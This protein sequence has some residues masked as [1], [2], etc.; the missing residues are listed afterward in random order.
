MRA[1]GFARDRWSLA[2]QRRRIGVGG[3]SVRQHRGGL[4]GRVTFSGGQEEIMFDAMLLGGQLVVAAAELVKRLMVAVLDDSSFLDHQDLVCPANGGEPMG[5]DKRGAPLHQIGEPFLNQGFRLGVETRGGLVE[6][7]NAGVGQDGARDR[8]SL[9][10]PARQLH[11]AFADD[12]VVLQLIFLG[13]LIHAGNGASP[14]DLLFRRMGLGKGH[15]LAN[16]P[17]EQKRIL[18]DHAQL[19]AIRLQPDGGE[20]DRIHQNFA[21]VGGMEGGNQPDDGGLARSR[22]SDQRRHRTQ[23]GA[24]RDVVQDGF[25]LLVGKGDVLEGDVAAYLGKRDRPVGV[26]VFGDLVENFASAFQ[27]SQRFRDLGADADHLKQWRGQV[28]EEHGVGEESAQRQLPCQDLAGA[29]KHDD[30]ADDAHESGRRQAHDRRR[31]QGA[32]DILQ[33]AFDARAEYL[34]LALLGMIA[35]DDPYSP[36]RLRQTA[37][38]FGVD[39][40]ALPENR[41]DGTKR[42]AQAES[43]YSEKA[44]GNGGHDRADANQNGE[45]NDGGEQAASEVHQTGANEVTHALDV[46]HDA[47]NQDAGLV[48]VVIRNGQSPDVLLHATAQLGDQ[49][50]RRLR[51]CLGK[52]KRREALDERCRQNHSHQRIKQFEMPLADDVVHQVLGGSRKHEPGDAVDDHQSQTQREQG[53]A[54]PNQLPDFGQH[55]EDLSF[56]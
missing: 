11:P 30:R 53:A 7:Q 8:D 48:G 55:L 9:A 33:Q 51:Q 52:R 1:A 3:R 25:L 15:V 20:I 27:S 54:R 28:S 32:K 29:H 36:Q 2:Q 10:L 39:L 5:D 23:P 31:G 49:L 17:V 42:L 12:G 45:G 40:G 16:A 43:K 4:F 19:G 14:E 6:N 44:E 26:F 24:K 37:S 13:K 41:A 35:L 22:G 38:D 47:R 21:L 18:Q 56:L 34:V 50:L 46:A